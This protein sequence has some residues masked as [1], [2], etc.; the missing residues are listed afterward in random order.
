[1][2]NE[3]RYSETRFCVYTHTRP[4]T[5]VVFYA[6]I[7]VISRPYSKHRRN[8]HWNGIVAKNNGDFIV[9]MVCEDMPWNLCCAF[10]RALIKVY[11][12]IDKGTGT[13]CNQTDGGDGTIG[14]ILTD[15]ARK[16][17]SQACMGR[18][19]T[20]ETRAKISKSN[21]GR[22]R[23]PELRQRLSLA[24]MGNSLSAESRK[25]ISNKLKGTVRTSEEKAKTKITKL[26]QRDYVIEQVSVVDGAVINRFLTGVVA[27]NNTGVARSQ[28][29]ICLSG[30]KPTAGGFFWRKSYDLSDFEQLLAIA[31]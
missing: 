20:A 1:M 31:V 11:G 22:P 27:E 9:T 3:Q 4:D 2:F 30:K 19:Q 10:E 13:L 21:S 7:G 24:N 17:K 26:R 29:C 6:G 25:L 12:R 14:V 28:I 5:N 15:E 16:R 18:I 8:K 23:S